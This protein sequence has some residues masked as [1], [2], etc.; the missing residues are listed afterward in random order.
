LRNNLIFAFILMALSI[1]CTYKAIGEPQS[2][3]DTQSQTPSP[4]VVKL[5]EN[6]YKIGEVTVDTKKREASIHG[7]VNMNVGL[8]EYLACS[9][10]GKLHESVLVLDVKPTILQVAL[11]LLG[12][13]AEG[14]FQYQGDPNPPKGDPVEIWVEWNQEEEKKLLRA[15][16]MIL[17]N[18][19]GKPMEHTNWV[20][21][22]SVIHE[23]R[24]IA[25]MEK[26][27]IATYHDPAAI[28]NNPL[29][30]GADDTV[31]SVNS[32]LVP[33]RGTPITLTIKAIGEPKSGS[34][35]P[36]EIEILAG[37][38]L[39]KKEGVLVQEN[40]DEGAL[41]ITRWNVTRD[42]DLNQFAVDVQ[43]VEPTTEKDYRLRVMVNTLETSDLVKYLGVRSIQT[44]DFSK[45][46]EISFDLDWNNQQDRTSLTAGLYICPLKSDN[47]KTEKD[48]L[49][50]EW[51]G[52]PPGKNICTNLWAS[53]N[54]VINQLYTDSG[55]PNENGSRDGWLVLPG[56]HRI[57]LLLDSNG[58]RVWADSKQL[59]YALHSL[60]FTSG[61]LYLQMS[62]G[63]NYS[64][65][66][67]YFDN[68]VVTA[69]GT[70]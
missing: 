2:P 55:P 13:E 54:G 33:Q 9:A 12:L 10:G 7:W 16:D 43:D 27:L 64:D 19:K 66:E 39:D 51:V 28:L 49:G 31:Y 21:T 42:G 24:F 40:F 50:F 60:S 35:L 29:P 17:D 1:T 26:S 44:V 59:C 46:K 36:P 57:K 52:V 5:K 3:S 14:D 45:A 15:E 48:F 34:A 37:K 68:I 18:K 47:P 70:Q 23:G 56:N 58:I 22:G 20:F 61:Y 6:L 69:V 30:E 65:R 32:N 38:G 67:V 41:D 8:I 53:V 62:S 25:E 11:I 63:A 4:K